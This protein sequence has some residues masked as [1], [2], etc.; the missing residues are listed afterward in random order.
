M[1]TDLFTEADLPFNLISETIAAPVK[2]LSPQETADVV[3]AGGYEHTPSMFDAPCFEVKINCVRECPGLICDR[4]EKSLEYWESSI[5]TAPWFSAEREQMVVLILDAK[6]RTVAHSIVSV[7]TLSECMCHPRDIFRPAI[8]LNAYSIVIMHNH[9]SGDATPSAADY[10]V[11]RNLKE[12]AA[13]LQI[14]LT[15]HIVVGSRTE[16]TPFF[17][18]KEAGLI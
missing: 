3:R 14:P 7:G 2:A 6:L 12:A 9:P 18:F 10:R 16:K 13:M 8:V 5:A 15:D 17:S 1:K 11:T 4:P